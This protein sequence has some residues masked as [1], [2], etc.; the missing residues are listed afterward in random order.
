MT[1]ST[2]IHSIRDLATAVHGRRVDLGLS[3][4]DLAARAGVSRK[5]IY[6]FEGGKP[7]AELGLMLRVLDAL[8]LNLELAG[9]GDEARGAGARARID[10][11]RLIDEHSHR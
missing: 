5:W 11:D 1:R 7:A 8:D 4:A 10:L 3:Q 2:T 6:E 9:T